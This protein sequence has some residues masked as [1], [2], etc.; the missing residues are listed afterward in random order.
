MNSDQQPPS[1]EQP[2]LSPRLK[3]KRRMSRRTRSIILYSSLS[4]VL[5]VCL[6]I[7]YYYYSVRSFAD[8]I[9]GNSKDI[10][11]M[12]TAPIE[13]GPPVPIP[14]PPEWDGTERVNILLLGG[15]SRGLKADSHP[16][17][18]TMMIASI[19]PVAKDIHLFS[20]LRDTYTSIDH[21]GSNRINAAVTFGGPR[22]A[23]STV[24]DLVGL[25]IHHY[26]YTDFEGFISLIDALGGIDFEVDKPMRRTD[27][28]DD[29]RYNINLE[30]GMQHM[31]GLTALQYVRF[32]GDIQSDYGRSDR[33][34][35][36]LSAIADEMK[37]T[38]SLIRLP[39]LLKSIAPYIETD[40]PPDDLLKLARLGM[41]L[42]TGNIAGIQLPQNGAFKDA[43]VNEM[44]VLVVDEDKIKSYVLEQLAS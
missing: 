13:G 42:D 35:R 30:A 22:L 5:A 33:Q 11:T 6:V 10:P 14:E 17:S 24:S 25:P 32:R 31:D 23:M 27:N 15:D 26:V 2:P 12:D 44:D 16:R 29:P 1:T 37:K 41:K 39:Q 8:E 7:A 18:D 20:I 9:Y 21:H 19:D 28:R 38:T 40:I 3:P 4:V 36:F 43:K 34:R